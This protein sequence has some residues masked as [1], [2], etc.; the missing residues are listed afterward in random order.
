[1]YGELTAAGS[2]YGGANGRR[3]KFNWDMTPQPIQ[4]KLKA[5]RG[6]RDKLPGIAYLTLTLRP[7]SR[8]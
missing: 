3:W 4:I 6:V 1:M 2:D 5:L 8:L 7:S